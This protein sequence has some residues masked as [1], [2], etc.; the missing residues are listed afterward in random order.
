MPQLTF[1]EALR[2]TSPDVSPR[3][4][5]YEDLLDSNPGVIRQGDGWSSLSSGKG[6]AKP[7]SMISLRERA[8]AFLRDDREREGAAVGGT[9]RERHI[10]DLAQE[11]EKRNSK[12]GTA[13]RPGTPGANS[14]LG[15][16]RGQGEKKG[17]FGRFKGRFGGK[18]ER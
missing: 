2:P 13:G 5:V 4:A 15:M 11:V 14:V 16:A 8:M 9:M 1:A 17:L 10:V 3:R 18:K 7:S 6:M 12:A